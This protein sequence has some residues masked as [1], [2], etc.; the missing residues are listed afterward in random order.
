MRHQ[1]NIFMAKGVVLQQRTIA[2]RNLASCL[3][4]RTPVVETMRRYIDITDINKPFFGTCPKDRSYSTRIA[5]C[6]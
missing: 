6:K 2:P 4:L 1:A 3:P 5:T